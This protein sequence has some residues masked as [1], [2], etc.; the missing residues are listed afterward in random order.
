MWELLYILILK[1]FRNGKII[2][3]FLVSILIFLILFYN[4]HIFYPFLIILIPD[5]FL[6]NIWNNNDEVFFHGIINT[7]S[8]KRVILLNKIILFTEANLIF[9]FIFFLLQITDFNHLVIFNS[10]LLLFF[11]VSDYLFIKSQFFKRSIHNLYINTSIIILTG[12][13]Y[14]FILVFVLIN[15]PI[16]IYLGVLIVFFVLN[17]SSINM[18]VNNF[19]FQ[20]YIKE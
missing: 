4:I 13:L 15:S 2:D 20:N 19:N 7:V 1:E 5:R 11:F 16:Y 6:N 12:I 17:I 9:L 18:I 3:L 8:K 14:S 10:Y